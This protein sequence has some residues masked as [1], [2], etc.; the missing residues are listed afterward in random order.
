MQLTRILVQLGVVRVAHAVRNYR[1][2]GR[3]QDLST[4]NLRIAKDE[5]FFVVRHCSLLPYPAVSRFKVVV[6]HRRRPR[7]IKLFPVL[8][9]SSC[10]PM[11][12]AFCCW[13]APQLSIT[14]SFKKS[15]SSRYE[16]KTTAQVGRTEA[17]IT[18]WRGRPLYDSCLQML[19][20]AV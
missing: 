18:Q 16:E 17:K 19:E 2:L 14:R 9:F 3:L 6:C 10:L 4:L 13:L 1:S 20:G 15:F 5:P 11:P 7:P 8:T 12:S